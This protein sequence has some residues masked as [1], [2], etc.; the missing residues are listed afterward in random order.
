M[1]WKLNETIIELWHSSYDAKTPTSRSY[2]EILDNDDDE[3]RRKEEEEE[4]LNI[5]ANRNERILIDSGDNCCRKRISSQ[6][7][8]DNEEGS[9]DDDDDDDD[10][11]GSR[12]TDNECEF[13][14]DVGGHQRKQ[15]GNGAKELDSF[16]MTCEERRKAKAV[17]SSVV[18]QI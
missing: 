6:I 4:I 1:S 17:A 7:I 9:D 13:N 5:D 2:S 14:V 12:T 3:T 15:I 11:N 8:D 18:W 10:E 16:L